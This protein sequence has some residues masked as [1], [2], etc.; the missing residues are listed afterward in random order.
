ML[1][2]LRGTLRA[3]M[4]SSL[5][6]SSVSRVALV[7]ASSLLNLNL[8]KVRQPLTGTARVVDDKQISMLST[9]LVA[10]VTAAVL[11]PTLEPSECMGKKRKKDSV[12]D[13]IQ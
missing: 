12:L 1:S 7:S 13:V 3:S 8:L 11:L 5:R 9:L 10:G 6:L 2:M 4:R